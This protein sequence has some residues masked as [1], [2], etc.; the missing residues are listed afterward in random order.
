MS[1]AFVERDAFWNILQPSVT[2]KNTKLEFKTLHVFR[3]QIKNSNTVQYSFE[4][5]NIYV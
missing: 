2:S 3:Y 5:I 1:K 4:L